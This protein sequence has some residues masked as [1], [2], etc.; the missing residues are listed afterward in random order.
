MNDFYKTYNLNSLIRESTCCKNPVNPPY[1]DL[2]LTNSP[3]S[4]Q[5]SFVVDT[6][7][8][9]LYEIFFPE[10]TAKKWHYRDYSN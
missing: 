5:K 10:V 6:G 8:S 2:F 1:I 7:L 9:S 3:N 4:S